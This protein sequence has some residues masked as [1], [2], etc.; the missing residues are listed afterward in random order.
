MHAKTVCND[1]ETKRL[2]KYHDLY[3]KSDTLLLADALENFR[4]TYLDVYRL[5]PAKFPSAS[6]S[7]WQAALKKTNVVLALVLDIDMLLIVEKGIQGEICHFI[8]RYSKA[9]NKYVKDYNKNK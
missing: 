1:F 8:S 7:T 3:L 4:N 9:N 6:G 5:D 2:G